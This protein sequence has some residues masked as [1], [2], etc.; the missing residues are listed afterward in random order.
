MALAQKPSKWLSGGYLTMLH[1]I[2]Q[3]IDQLVKKG[4]E[5]T[6]ITALDQHYVRNQILGLLQLDGFDIQRNFPTDKAMPDLLEE[7]VAFAVETNVIAD[8]LDD[9]EILSAKIMD[10]FLSKPTEINQQFYQKYDTSPK[11]ATDY[12]YHLS[13]YSNYIQMKR[14][15]KNVHYKAQSLYGT[16]DITINL[17]K[18][19]KDPEQIKRKRS[20]K[21][22]LEYPRCLLCPENEGYLGRTGHPA[23]SNHRIIEV[24]LE[25]ET[26][27]LQYSPYVYY[28]EHSILFASEHRPMHI[29]RATFE[30]LL[31][32]VSK[33]PHY[34]MGS[35][36]D[37]PIVGGS[38]LSHDHYQGGRYTFAMMKAVD[39]F[40]F[41]MKEF[42]GVAAS[43]IKWPMSVIRLRSK[44]KEVLIDAASYIL[45]H[46]RNYSD[47]D[48]HILAHTQDTPH[49]TITPI[50]RME[51]DQYTLDLVLRNNRTSDA[52][53]FGIFHPHEDVHHIKKENIGLIEVMGL[54]VLPP[55]LKVELDAIKANLID[56]KTVVAK[57]HQ[58]WVEEIKQQHGTIQPSNVDTILQDA[59]GQKFIR[60]LEDSGVF[61]SN[62]EGKAAFK[63]FIQSL[64][65]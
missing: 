6:L 38:I 1:H 15:E 56:H 55:R 22:T 32:F 31:A 62:L 27:F 45:D 58:P 61:K 8:V 30:R 9:K 47:P 46:W 53:P 33:F 42:S 2:Y 43:V 11:I 3:T 63:R 52:H 10:C 64:Q 60:V 25:E 13:K 41:S 36:A 59:L 5:H 29:S 24:S 4:I 48:A 19:E 35:N 39:E 50:A 34:F 17:S 12:F 18:P 20:I 51:A 37:L 16:L 49:N 57:Y 26:W 21:Q 14:I 40:Q 28:N 7:L 44:T 54:A 23:R 65:N